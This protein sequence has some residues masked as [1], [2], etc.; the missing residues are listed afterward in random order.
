V[1]KAKCEEYNFNKILKD[2]NIWYDTFFMTAKLND[3]FSFLA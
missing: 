2:I 3:M 1:F